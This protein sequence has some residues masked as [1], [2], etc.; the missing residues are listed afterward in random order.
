MTS[1]MIRY[2]KPVLPIPEEWVPHLRESYA[3][4]YFANFGPAVREF[5][6]Q[7]GT[8]YARGR[9][10][11]TAPNATNGLTVALQALGITGK[12]LTPSY[13]F[14]ATAQALLMAG[15]IPVFCDVAEDTWELDP[16]AV[17]QAL[18]DSE[19]RAI[20]HVRAYGF[21]HDLEWLEA[22]AA[23]RGIHLIVDAAAAI[24]G[25][26]SLSGKVGQQGAMEVFSFH[27]TKVFGIGE[28]SAIFARPE[29]EEALR[30]SSN[31]GIRYPDVT[32]RGQ[33]SKMSDFQAAIGLA[34]LKRIDGFVRQRYAVAEHYHR[35]LTSS[36]VVSRLQ[37]PSLSPWQSYP[38]RLRRG[39]DAAVILQRAASMGLELKRG[40]HLPLHRTAYFSRYAT[41]SLPVTDNLSSNVLCL[42][43]HS[44]MPLDTAQEVTRRFLAAVDG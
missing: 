18:R 36:A 29:H 32:G 25:E 16:L 9:A 41:G 28:G 23:D 11:I 22:V 34:V 10:V 27:A 37:P 42:P 3:T 26:H 15:C 8:R 24:G 4:G 40:Y 43:V 35:A 5:E 33:N 30:T 44:D 19:I 1:G 12:V 6:R 2:I 7:L 39:C 38:V 31:F 20:L 21:G 14:P 13:T 17:E